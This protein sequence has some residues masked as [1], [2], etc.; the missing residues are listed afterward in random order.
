MAFKLKASFLN[1]PP[2][3]MGTVLP[4]VEVTYNKSQKDDGWTDK[5]KSGYIFCR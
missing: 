2:E 1:T 5:T 4:E 3:G